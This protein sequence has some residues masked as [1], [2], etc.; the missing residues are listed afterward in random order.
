[1]SGNSTDFSQDCELE[2]EGSLDNCSH[3][4]CL[5]VTEIEKAGYEEVRVGEVGDGTILMWREEGKELNIS[6]LK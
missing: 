1:M 3:E 6:P 2:P 5:T 4:T